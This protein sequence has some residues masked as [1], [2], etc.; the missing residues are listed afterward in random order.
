MVD[1]KCSFTM[2]HAD[3]LLS[4]IRRDESGVQNLVGLSEDTWINPFDPNPT[5]SLIILTDACPSY[6]VTNDILTSQ[7]KGEVAYANFK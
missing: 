6:E 5:N 7:K 3:H 4:R 2:L 1:D